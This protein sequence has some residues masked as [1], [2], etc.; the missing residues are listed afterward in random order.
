MLRIA[1]GVTSG[2]LAAAGCGSKQPN[3]PRPHRTWRQLR[4]PDLA[5][6]AADRMPP[7]DLVADCRRRAATAHD[8]RSGDDGLQH[9][10]RWEPLRGRGLSP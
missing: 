9:D 10:Q 6:P 2:I 8:P 1:C 3:S 5:A 7:V 4:L